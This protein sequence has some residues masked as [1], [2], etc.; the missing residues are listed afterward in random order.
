MGPPP[1]N[2][3]P[4]DAPAPV[5]CIRLTSLLLWVT[6]VGLLAVLSRP[7]Q[8]EALRWVE[9]QVPPAPQQVGRRQPL[10]E[11][12]RPSFLRLSAA[13]P[14]PTPAAHLRPTASAW[15]GPPWGTAALAAAAVPALALGLGLARWPV[16]GRGDRR[17]TRGLQEMTSSFSTAASLGASAVP[18]PPYSPCVVVIGGAGRVGGSTVRHLLQFAAEEGWAPRVVV[19][20]RSAAAFLQAQARWRRQSSS[21]QLLSLIDAVQFTEADAAGDASLDALLEALRPDLVVHTA[22]P[23]QGQPRPIPLEACL[24]HGVPRYVDVCDDIHLCAVARETLDRKARA[25]GATCA[26]AAGVWPG[27]SNLMAAECVEALRQAT[28]DPTPGAGR[29]V[30]YDFYTAGTGGAGA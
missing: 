29:A 2:G 24:R 27:V 8:L 3:A 14:R 25:A 19:A 22:G 16:T 11:G 4:P 17:P 7:D 28:T 12:R 6:A 26:I 30:V 18:Q 20:G 9:L 13:L 1:A 10:M 15:R 5:N 23:F 21:A